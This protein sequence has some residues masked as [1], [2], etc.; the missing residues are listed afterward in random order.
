M[1]PLTLATLF[2]AISVSPAAH[3]ASTQF[4]HDG[5]RYTYSTRD[6]GGAKVIRGVRD[7]GARYRYVVRGNKVTGQFDGI[8]VTFDVRDTIGAAD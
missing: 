3:A 8:P 5:Q 4:E 2:L 1:K 7:D 6:V